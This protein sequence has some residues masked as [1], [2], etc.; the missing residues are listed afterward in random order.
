MS[1][2]KVEL[3]AKRIYIIATMLD[4]DE[5]DILTSLGIAMQL[6]RET[7]DRL[8]PDPPKKPRNAETR[9]GLI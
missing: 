2:E 5:F 4:T 7:I 6:A 9:E 3:N 1:D 8:H